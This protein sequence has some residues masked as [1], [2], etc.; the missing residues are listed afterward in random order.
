MVSGDTVGS[1]TD[2]IPNTAA[3]SGQR[4][5][6]VGVPLPWT[7]GA[8]QPRR[9]VTAGPQGL[10]GPARCTISYPNVVPAGILRDECCLPL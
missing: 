3:F 2:V 9:P 1:P 8:W 5:G 7:A 4:G 10:Q 6:Q